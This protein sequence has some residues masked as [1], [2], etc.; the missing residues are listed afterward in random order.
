LPED[1]PKIRNSPLIRPTGLPRGDEEEKRFCVGVLH[2][3]G[4][5][6]KEQG[7]TLKSASAGE[8]G[9]GLPLGKVELRSK[10]TT[11]GR[12]LQSLAV[13]ES[14]ERI[15]VDGDWEGS[16]G[17]DSK[18]HGRSAEKRKSDGRRRVD[19]RLKEGEHGRIGGE[20]EKKKK[21]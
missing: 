16:G 1:E 20:Y 15:R 21:N 5:G 8:N 7:Q 11:K 14:Q 4:G 18:R 10:K 9:Q 17:A 6:G 12:V 2:H 13:G 19:G 3:Q